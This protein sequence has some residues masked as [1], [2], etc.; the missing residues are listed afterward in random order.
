VLEAF[1]QLRCLAASFLSSVTASV[2]RPFSA[3]AC[4]FAQDFFAGAVGAGDFL[5]QSDQLGAL[6]EGVF[7]E[8]GLFLFE[9]L[10]KKIGELL[11]VFA[12]H[13]FIL[14]REKNWMKSLRNWPGSARRRYFSSLRARQIPP[15]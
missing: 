4:F 15:Q 6:L 2:M 7:V 14:Q 8:G 9:F 13:K 5:L 3:T 12:G 10:C 11:V 1:L